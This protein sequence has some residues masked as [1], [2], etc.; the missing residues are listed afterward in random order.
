MLITSK[1]RIIK[2]SRILVILF[3]FLYLSLFSITASSNSGNNESNGVLNI[4]YTG[5]SHGVLEHC[6]CP[7]SRFGGIANRL[8]F[9][10]NNMERDNSILVDAGDFF[11]L[12][13]D[14]LKN[15]YAYEILKSL[16]YDALNIGELDLGV[17]INK[18]NDSFNLP[19]ISSNILNKNIL[20]NYIQP[21][22]IID[23]NGLK[24]GIIGSVKRDFFINKEYRSIIS[25]IDLVDLNSQIA[26][27]RKNVDLLIFLSH[28]DRK[29]EKALFMENKNI[30]I[31]ISGHNNI[32]TAD[33][34]NDENRIFAGAGK[35]S[36]YIGQIVLN[37]E[38]SGLKKKDK[39]ISITN[40]FH[41]MVIDSVGILKETQELLDEYNNSIAIKI[42][43]KNS[44]KNKYQFY[45]DKFCTKCHDIKE[46]IHSN[47]FET[48]K[49]R[50]N[51]NECYYCHTTGYGSD[52]GFIPNSGKDEYE[53]INC[54]MCHKINKNTVFNEKERH[55]VKFILSV[56]CKRC[57]RKPHDMEFN[58]HEKREKLMKYH[59]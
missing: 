58:Y 14:S 26:K 38:S 5:N 23:K 9:I 13:N 22:K 17:Y 51:K 30:D 34:F 49:D 19:V 3:L 31:F 16:N 44:T 37:W 41:K 53:N 35:N 25:K 59:K 55:N 50:K 45:E 54:S 11:T 18:F 29:T 27:L 32:L 48:I 46:T 20:K 8:N 28:L 52:S 7:G 4:Y 2:G 10:R 36:E 40:L 21:Y 43:K 6:G 47:A 57:H 42:L 24:V 1:Y 12:N 56:T 15:Y 39:E 33:T